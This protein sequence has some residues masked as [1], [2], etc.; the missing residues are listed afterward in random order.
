MLSYPQVYTR[1]LNRN[2]ANDAAKMF[3][4]GSAYSHQDHFFIFIYK[5]QCFRTC[6]L[7]PVHVRSNWLWARHTIT[8]ILHGVFIFT[9]TIIIHI[10]SAYTFCCE[11][12]Q[13][14][15]YSTYVVCLHAD[16]TCWLC[17]FSAGKQS[18][19]C[20]VNGPQ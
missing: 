6:V 15:R 14:E 10:R 2:S 7:I 18:Y 13:I 12:V 5:E 19:L 9:C 16:Q 3:G 4:S 17:Y 20:T 8:H 1:I 11:I